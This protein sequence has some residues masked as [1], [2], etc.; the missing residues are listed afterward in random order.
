[1]PLT[2]FSDEVRFRFKSKNWQYQF[3]EI[4]ELILLKKKRKYFLENG[5][6]I[7][8]TATAYYCMLFSNL[9]DLHY[10]IPAVLSYAL[11]VAL[12]FSDKTEFVY[13]LFVKDIYQKEIKTKIA[14]KDHVLVGE[15]MDYYLDLQF[16]RSVKITA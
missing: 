9:I 4:K 2:I 8:V 6:F 15:Q 10:V 3:D 5:S 14:P 12:W 13:F 1:M 16:E 11:I 7:A